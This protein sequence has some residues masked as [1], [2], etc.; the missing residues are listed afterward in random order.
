[1]SSCI[2][3]QDPD[4]WPERGRACQ[5]CWGRMAAWLHQIPDLLTELEV[6]P[7]RSPHARVSGSRDR[8]LPIRVDPVDLAGPVNHGARRLLARGALGLD[9]DQ[10][11]HLSVATVLDGWA[12]DW[13]TALG[14][15]LPEPTV[16]A[17]ARW[18]GDRLDWACDHHDALDEFAADLRELHGT[19]LALGGTLPP[20]PEVLPAPCPGC[21][22]LT[23]VRRDDRI[24]CG[25]GCPRLM[26]EDDYAAYC[27]T[28]TRSD[29]A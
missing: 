3:C 28:L 16:P 11:G 20:R 22:M 23:L 29:A 21:G 10:T 13:A 1:M 27:R 17:L 24:G 14:H 12:R 19:L 2:C 18:L 8:P 5:R 6:T 15:R 7:G 9:D 26:T 25:A 4:R